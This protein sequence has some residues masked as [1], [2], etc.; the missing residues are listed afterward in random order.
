MLFCLLQ[1]KVIS[2]PNPNFNWDSE[3]FFQFLVEKHEC[4]PPTMNVQFQRSTAI[5][6]FFF[7][8]TIMNTLLLHSNTTNTL[9]CTSMLKITSFCTPLIWI[10]S[11]CTPL[12]QK[13]L[14]QYSRI[15]NILPYTPLLWIHCSCT[16]LQQKISSIT[17]ELWIFFST[18]H[19]YEYTPHALHCYKK[20]P[21]VLQN[22]EYSPLHPIVM[23]T[24]LMHSTAKKDS[25]ST[26]EL[27]IFFSTPHCYEYTAHAFHC[28]KKIPPVLQNYEYSPLHSIVMNTLLKHSNA[29][30]RLLQYSR[31]MNILPCTPL[32]WI[33][34]SSTPMLQKDS[35]STP[36]LW[37][38]SP[39][40]HCYEYTPQ[41]LQCYELSQIFW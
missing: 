6:I 35:S 37:I 19:C 30:K 41:A 7:N 27:W 34:S 10:H 23:N 14:L 32:L 22:Y 33:H 16:A 31:T 17:P 25:S 24:L 12:L 13:R 39:A 28:Y 1:Q 11:S 40:L 36:E 3:Y 20:T 9:A 26:P 21:S 15:M 18:P 5:N 8:C 29:T 2:E 38:F 4:D